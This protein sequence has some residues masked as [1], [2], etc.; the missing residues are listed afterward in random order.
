MIGKNQ[1]FGVLSMPEAQFLEARS[2]PKTQPDKP[3]LD[4]YAW[5]TVEF[6]KLKWRVHV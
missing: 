2:T 6:N 4:L 3:Y 1:V 5:R